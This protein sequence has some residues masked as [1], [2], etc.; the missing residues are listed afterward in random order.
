MIYVIS[1]QE[2]GYDGG[3]LRVSREGGNTLAGRPSKNNYDE[4]E[5]TASITI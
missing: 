2:V 1:L 5:A 3:A 4:P